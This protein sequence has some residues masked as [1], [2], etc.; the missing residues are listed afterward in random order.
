MESTQNICVNMFSLHR[1]KYLPKGN[2][3]QVS[4][5]IA[6]IPVLSFARPQHAK[7][8]HPKPLSHLYDNILYSKIFNWKVRI[9]LLQLQMAFVKF[10]QSGVLFDQAMNHF[11]IKI[12]N[13]QETN[14]FLI[15]FLVAYSFQLTFIEGITDQNP[16][17]QTGKLLRFSFLFSPTFEMP[18]FIP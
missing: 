14:L 7:K 4:K 1:K 8:N 12:L 5:L 16:S 9:H 13:V 17:F 10:W 3:K 6:S 11:L 2:K 18:T 15:H